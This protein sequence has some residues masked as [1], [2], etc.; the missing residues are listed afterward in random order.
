MSY[1]GSLTNSKKRP[2]LDRS[3][4]GHVAPARHVDRSADP[5]VDVATR[6]HT[7]QRVLAARLAEVAAAVGD[8]PP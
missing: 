8:Y 7:A 3:E 6:Q 4:A 2:T 1:E 5:D